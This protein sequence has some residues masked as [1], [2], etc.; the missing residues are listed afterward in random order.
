MLVNIR[1]KSLSSLDKTTSALGLLHKQQVAKVYSQGLRRIIATREHHGEHELVHAEFVTCEELRGRSPELS[2]GATRQH[3]Y[4]YGVPVHGVPLEQVENY[5]G[6]HD[7][8]EAGDLA[9]DLLLLGEHDLVR[10]DVHHDPAARG[11][12]R[13]RVVQVEV[14]RHAPQVLVVRAVVYRVH[15]V[16]PALELVLVLLLDLLPPL[17]RVD[18]AFGYAAAVV[19][20]V[21]EVSICS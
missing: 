1:I 8:G 17:E 5:V 10:I 12:E 19:V 3:V 18:V 20:I 15:E 21:L 13:S 14:L 6:S 11:D 4:H 2:S 7:L 9:L 16:L